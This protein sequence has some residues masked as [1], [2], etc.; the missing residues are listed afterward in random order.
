MHCPEAK[1][2]LDM[3]YATQIDLRWNS[4]AHMLMQ[5]SQMCVACIDLRFYSCDK[6]MPETFYPQCPA[7]HRRCNRR[8]QK[9]RLLPIGRSKRLR[10]AFSLFPFPY[11]CLGCCGWGVGACGW[12]RKV[13]RPNTQPWRAVKSLRE[14][15]A[16]D[17]GQ[18]KPIHLCL[19]LLASEQVGLLLRSDAKP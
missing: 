15:L 12:M 14:R 18:P 2:Y 1:S 6:P 11:K 8:P 13:K 4:I 19:G 3:T 7:L 10:G 9:Q 5:V 16:I 17:K